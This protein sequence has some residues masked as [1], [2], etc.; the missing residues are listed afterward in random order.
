MIKQEEWYTATLITSKEVIP[1][2]AEIHKSNGFWA[3]PGMKDCP[4]LMSSRIGVGI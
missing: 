1:V 3:K 4:R 2:K